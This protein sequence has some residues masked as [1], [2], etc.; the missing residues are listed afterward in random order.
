MVR[1]PRRRSNAQK[2]A[3]VGAVAAHVGMRMRLRRSLMNVDAATVARMIH[4]P[5][6]TLAAYENG[7]TAID[8]SLLFRFAVA[9]E[10]PMAWFLDGMD[11]SMYSAVDT[12]DRTAE[13]I[14][15]EIDQT[16]RDR[17][18]LGVLT[19]YFGH[20]DKDAQNTLMDVA[21]ALAAKAQPN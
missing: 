15:S 9:L 11:I 1:S 19:A 6:S 14:A 12:P 18:A 10:V 16:Q 7:S 4:V 2:E 17:Q 3:R 8:V 5:E 21:R 13:S 20:L